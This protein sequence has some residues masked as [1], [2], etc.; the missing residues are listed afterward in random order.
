MYFKNEVLL[1]L[2]VAGFRD[3]TVHGDYTDEPATADH[4]ELVFTAIR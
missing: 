3:I 4:E 2:K 1:M